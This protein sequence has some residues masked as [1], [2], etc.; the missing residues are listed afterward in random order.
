MNETRRS[1]LAAFLSL[2]V[3]FGWFFF[4]GK[5]R[6]L[7]TPEEKA[8]APQ[9][10]AARQEPARPSLPLEE[11]GPETIVR[12]ETA[13]AA[14]EWTTRGGGLK[15]ILMKR[16]REGVNKE[17]PLIN[18]IPFEG[19]R[20]LSLSCS[21]CS[22]SLPDDR[23]YRQVAETGESIVFEAAGEGLTVRKEYDWKNDQHLLNLR[24]T[25]Q[26]R[27]S[28]ELRGRLGIGW[29]ARQF[30]K[31]PKGTLGFLRGPE[32]KRSFI[33][34]RGGKVVREGGE[35]I[36]TEL[37]GPVSWIGIEDRYFLISL[38]S[39]RVSSDQILRLRGGGEDLEVSL[40]PTEVAL[41]PGGRL[42]EVYS[43]YLGPKERGHLQVAGVGL[44]GAIDYG[45]FS[46]FA[47]P[48]LKLLQLFHA[49]VRNWG[50]AIILLTLVVKL[51]MN[52][53]TVRSLKQM[54][55]MQKLQPRLAE[56]KEKYKND[57]QRLN[58]ETM[59]LFKNHKVNPMGGCL[60]MLLQMPIYIALYKVLYNS[61]EIYHAPFFWFYRDLS[62][63]DP[64]FVLP[65]LLG[66]LMVAQQKLTP[67]ASAD[68]AQRQMMMIMPVMFTAFML[69]LPVGLVIYILVNTIA[70][71]LQQWMYQKEVGWLD[72]LKGDLKGRAVA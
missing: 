49:V 48:I 23:Q 16:Y 52:P 69:F 71:V 40:Y 39:R 61:I 30:P 1:L 68:P 44:E 53:L 3:L 54:K 51:L 50:I 5:D 20:G 41:P 2:A 18:L 45:W 35:E 26:N 31:R 25:V 8:P 42:E 63:P 64:Y 10:E 12:K 36:A 70:S 57:K 19:E 13:L 32:D 34:N 9:A 38:V 43:L 66:I 60:P 6:P 11:P 28:N 46:L 21:N 62:A 29:S 15:K 55:E 22:F 24:V 47:I 65:I 7:W 37:I 14:I 17:S 67:S 56:L 72:L 59:Q 33:Y 58:M 27:S 4:F